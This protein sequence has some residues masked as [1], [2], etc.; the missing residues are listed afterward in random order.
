MSVPSAR[1]VV[2][3]I[4]L[5]SSSAFALGETRANDHR[6]VVPDTPMF[7]YQPAL[8]GVR[9]IAVVLVILFH[10]GLP[11]L[12]GGYVGV[13]VFFTL[14]GYLITSL[15]LAE[16]DRTGSVAVGAFYSRRIR[17]LFPASLVCVCLIM[18][19]RWSGA[20]AKVRGLRTDIIGALLHSFNW[21]KLAGTTSYGDLFLGG[22]SPLAHY[23]SLAIEEQF[24][25]LWPIAL[26]G[27]LRLVGRRHVERVVIGLFISFAAIAVAIAKTFGPDAAYWATPARLPEILA[28]AAL[29]C[30]LARGR[31]VP[32]LARLVGPLALGLVVAAA[33][34]LPSGTGPAYSGALPFFSLL[35]VGLVY[36]LQVPGLLRRMLSTRPLFAIGRVSY[37]LYLFHWPVFVYLRERSWDLTHPANLG[38]ALA[39]TASITA[40]SYRFIE[41]PIR[42]M[43]TKPLATVTFAGTATAATIGLAL[44]ISPSIAP[45]AVPADLARRVAIVPASSIDPLVTSTLNT[46]VRSN[47]TAIRLGAPPSRPVRILLVGDST[48]QSLTVGLQ[49]WA[50]DHPEYAQVKGVW[51]PSMSFLRSGEISDQK[52]R[53][54]AQSAEPFFQDALVNEVPALSP[55]VV[56]L[57]TTLADA[58]DRKW[59]D[60]EGVLGPQD[61]RYGTASS[62]GRCTVPV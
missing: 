49:M 41:Q 62:N 55:D 19:A 3:A 48:L 39:V 52:I 15:L 29:A 7:G 16:H 57:M 40:L 6:A 1:R 33:L 4:E 36:S 51:A 44:L 34:W 38:F 47:E 17:R 10:A 46:S 21:V 8:D 37:G 28:G 35:S 32:T 54:F 30:V 61:A 31:K 45:F 56:V 5:P 24:Y 9:A 12:S 14:S 25:W 42:H 13:S 2:T 20:F 53:D 11:S 43:S 50:G 59:S 23:W 26:L 58:A 18:L 27:L 60:A 22:I